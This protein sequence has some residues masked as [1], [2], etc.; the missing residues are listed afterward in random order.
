MV[1]AASIF[2]GLTGAVLALFSLVLFM[3]G[4]TYREMSLAG[5]GAGMLLVEIAIASFVVIIA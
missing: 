2:L 5:W 3:V 1:L 4:I